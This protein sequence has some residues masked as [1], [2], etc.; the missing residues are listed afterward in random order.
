VYASDAFSGIAAGGALITGIYFKP[1]PGLRPFGNTLPSVEILMSTTPRGPDSLNPVFAGNLGIRTLTVFPRG[2]LTIGGS[3]GFDI[4]V[5]L[6]TP[7]FY[8]PADG[9]LLLEVRNYAPEGPPG[10]GSI[11]GPFDAESALGDPISRVYAYDVNATIGTTDTLGLFTGFAVT[12]IP[13][14]SAFALFACA[15][16]V[17]LWWRHRRIL[18]VRH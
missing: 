5:F 10:P 8:R 9:N 3:G 11:V 1:E 13:E 4:R 14:P 12:V 15:G 17:V 7:Y 2:P 18:T 6:Q 16:G